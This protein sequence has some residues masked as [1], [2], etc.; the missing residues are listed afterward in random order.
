M[1]TTDRTPLSAPGARDVRGAFFDAL[2]RLG[3]TRPFEAISVRDVARE[4][5]FSTR[6]FYNRFRSKYDLVIRYYALA[7]HD[8][9]RRA[10]AGE[11]LPP[12][13]ERVRDGLVRFRRDRAMFAGALR[14]AVGPESFATTFLSHACRSTSEHVRFATGKPLPAA[15]EPVLRHYYA[16]FVWVLCEWLESPSPKSVDAFLADAV[17]ALPAPLR[18]T[19]L[20]PRDSAVPEPSRR[21]RAAAPRG[22]RRA[23]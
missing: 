6:T 22:C 12:W 17:A 18:A 16:G 8:A 14:D 23:R 20:P 7:D 19:L 13:A 5:G 9:A 15:L 21:P 3:L 1:E 2:R 4:A 10:R 11:A